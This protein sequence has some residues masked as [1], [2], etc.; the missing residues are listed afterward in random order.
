MKLIEHHLW[1][2]LSFENNLIHSNK[3]IRTSEAKSVNSYSDLVKHVAQVAFYN[4]GLTLFY[5]GQSGDYR[6]K[7]NNSSLFPSI[8]RPDRG[9]KTLPKR[10]IERRFKAM[11]YACELMR[12]RYSSIGRN[13]LNRFHEIIWAILQHY[14]V[15][16]TPLLDLS[17]SLQV[18]ASF[19]SHSE[20]DEGYVFI[21]GV[22]HTNGSISYFTD[23]EMLNIKLQGI[24]PP[25]AMR[26]YFQEGY[27]AA[28]FP[29]RE[30]ERRLV[31]HNFSRRLIAKFK[32][33]K[34]HFWDE[35]FAKVP[36]EVLFP[37][38]DEVLELCQTIQHELQKHFG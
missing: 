3:E 35:H 23:Y 29:V 4:P 24:C 12:K 1:S 27:L 22:P 20:G 28:T 6:D 2:H 16:A 32:F 13:K 18:A 5:R 8:Y 17:S 9:A 33:K 31:N 38:D 15:C 11:N 19:A 14:E 37:E 36:K 7:K 25:S 10:T 34:E 30:G 21:L 26:P